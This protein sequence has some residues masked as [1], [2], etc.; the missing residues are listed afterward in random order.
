MQW[1]RSAQELKRECLLWEGEQI[2][3]G[4]LCFK[5]RIGYATQGSPKPTS[6]C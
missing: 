4:Q 2:I 1:A 5:P 6:P 3:L